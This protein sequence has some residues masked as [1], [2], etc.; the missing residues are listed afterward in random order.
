[1]WEGKETNVCGNPTVG[2]CSHSCCAE[3]PTRAKTTSCSVLNP[4]HPRDT[5]QVLNKCVKSRYVAVHRGWYP[6]TYVALMEIFSEN[7]FSLPLWPSSVLSMFLVT[8]RVCN[9]LATP[10]VRPRPKLQDL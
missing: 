8:L 5:Q 1:M 3:G 9:G 10:Q 2:R 6:N 4:Q 7:S